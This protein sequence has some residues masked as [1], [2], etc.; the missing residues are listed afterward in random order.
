MCLKKNF[1]QDYSV[2][3]FDVYNRDIF[4]TLH[5]T[6][7]ACTSAEGIGI[8]PELS[9]TGT[10]SPLERIRGLLLPYWP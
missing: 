3:A 6:T 4:K 7:D 5:S 1:I 2:N 10:A 8:V 9:R